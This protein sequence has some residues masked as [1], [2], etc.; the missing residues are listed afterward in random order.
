MSVLDTKVK[1]GESPK[2][3]KS[4]ISSLEK[5]IAQLEHQVFCCCEKLQAQGWNFDVSAYPGGTDSA[6]LGPG[7]GCCGQ[8]IMIAGALVTG[9]GG[10]EGF[11]AYDCTGDLTLSGNPEWILIHP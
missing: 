3:Y 11:Y 10:T 7:V 5:R 6:G 4:G 1:S 9:G 8:T 2:F